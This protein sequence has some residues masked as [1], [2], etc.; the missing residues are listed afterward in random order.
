MIIYTR[1]RA[2]RRRRAEVWLQNFLE[3]FAPDV[4]S[5]VADLLYATMVWPANDC[6]QVSEVDKLSCATLHPSRNEDHF[7]VQG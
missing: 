2:A 4:Q 7:K 1:P 3:I 6:W 5:C